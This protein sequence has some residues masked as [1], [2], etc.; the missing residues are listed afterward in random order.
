MN[1]L[2]NLLQLTSNIKIKYR[3]LSEHTGENFNIFDILGVQSSELS[4]SA[5]IANLLNAKG[6]HGQKDLFLKLFIKQV[7]QYFT[8]DKDRYV[9]LEN[10]SNLKSKAVKEYYA[11]RVNYAAKE[12]GRI[13]IVVNNNLNNIIIENKI[14]ASDQPSQLLRY[15]KFDNK[16]TIF[17]LTLNGKQ[18]DENSAK[19][20]NIGKEYVCISYEKDIVVWLENCIAEMTNKLFIHAT[21]NQYLIL[22]KNLTN[23]PNNQNMQNELI[24]LLFTDNNMNTAKTIKSTL[25]NINLELEKKLDS[26]AKIFK[27]DLKYDINETHKVKFVPKFKYE[28][29]PII[30]LEVLKIGAEQSIDSMFIQLIIK[31]YKLCNKIWSHNIE[32]KEKLRLQLNKKI[33][34]FEYSYDFEKTAQEIYLD[35]KLQIDQIIKVLQQ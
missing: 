9:L 25:H 3:E 26:L 2:K 11:G 12:G 1:E 8:I 17:Y 35:V 27:N 7:K 21:L 4:H 32:L 33:E 15:F 14:Y 18:P 10:F 20:L 19:G 30:N 5:V 16:A 34:G 28:G 22:I 29:N 23:Q 13:D 24:Q 31:D 6:K